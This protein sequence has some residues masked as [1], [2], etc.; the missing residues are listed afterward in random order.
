[1]AA[2]AIL[3]ANSVVLVSGGGRG[4]TAR[5]VIRLAQEAQ[6]TFILL[7]RSALEP[8]SIPGAESAQ[9][10]NALKQVLIRHAQSQGEKPRPARIQAQARAILAS[11]EVR[12]TLRA[13]EDAGGKAEYLVSDVTNFSELTKA[14]AQ[15]QARCGKVTGILHGAG[16]LADK[17]LDQK[18]AADFEKVFSAKVDGL[19]N[20]LACVDPQDLTFLVLFSSIVGFYGNPGQADYAM[21]NEVLNKFAYKFKKNYPAC[22]VLSMGWGPWDG[23]MVTPALRKTFEEH[24]VRII[25]S[26]AGAE[27]LVRNLTS[28]KDPGVQILVGDPPPNLATGQDQQP[29]DNIPSFPITRSGNIPY[30]L[31]LARQSGQPP[32]RSSSIRSTRLSRSATIKCSRAS[33]LTTIYPL[34][35]LFPSKKYRV[36]TQE[37]LP[38]MRGSRALTSGENPSSTTR[39][40]SS[41]L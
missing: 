10:E 38:T 15:A 37:R 25:P 28:E 7:G 31:P 11:R 39:S 26:D 19:D 1:M 40:R 17:L 3:N 23:G 41:W 32:P 24:Q 16:N 6:S 14:V 27:L 36:R 30:C 33:F 22:R 34:N 12:E 9:D 21:A 4:I 8:E 2:N 5:C 35:S 13:V 29:R 20:L 18:T